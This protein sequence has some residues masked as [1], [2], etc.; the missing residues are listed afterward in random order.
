MDKITLISTFEECFEFL[1]N[2]KFPLPD[3][4]S[5]EIHLTK[6]N[7]YYGICLHTFVDGKLIHVIG[8]NENFIRKGTKQAIK[9]TIIHELLH[10]LPNCNNHGKVWKS[11]AKKAELLTGCPIRTTVGTKEGFNANWLTL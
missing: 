11:F 8:L 3:N 6:K 9:A 5:N 4:I 1:L 7:S 2:N 10:T